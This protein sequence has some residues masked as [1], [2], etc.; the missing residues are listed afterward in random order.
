MNT[1]EAAKGQWEKIFAYYGLP[2]ITGKRHFK[3]KC[4]IC[5]KK[6]KFRIDDQDGRGTYICTCSSGTGFQ[7]LEKTQ[8]KSFKQLADEIDQ[9][10]GNNREKE[11]P[12]PVSSNTRSDREKFISCYAQMPDLKDTSAAGYLQNRGIFTLPA[13]HIRFCERQPTRKGMAVI[14]Y[15]AMWALATDSK[16]QL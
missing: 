1:A 2:P 8:G 7:L 13:E 5:E 15:Q 16:G 14:N 12:K 9:L 6:G 4:P 11:A 10:L 3:G